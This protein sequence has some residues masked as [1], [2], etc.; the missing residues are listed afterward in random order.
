MGRIGVGEHVELRTASIPTTLRSRPRVTASW[1]A[2]VYSMPFNRT[3]VAGPPPAGDVLPSLVLVLAL[4]MALKSMAPGFNA[5]SLSKLRRS[6][7]G[8]YARSPTTPETVAVVVF[9]N[10]MAS[11]TVTCW[12]NSPTSSRISPRFPG[13]LPGDALTDADR[14]PGFP[15]LTSCRPAAA[16]GCGNRLRRRWSPCA[17]PRCRGSSR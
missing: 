16:R 11:V 3:V 9:T 7:A 10:G 1:L 13:L 12:K 2:P 15:A 5:I 17:S 14:N 8:L 4:F 6:A